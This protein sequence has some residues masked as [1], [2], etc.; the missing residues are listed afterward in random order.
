MFLQ[1]NNLTPQNVFTTIALWSCIQTHVTSNAGNTVQFCSQTVTSL[2]RMQSFLNKGDD[3]SP[4]HSRKGVIT[5]V[6]KRSYFSSKDE[7]ISVVADTEYERNIDQDR[8]KR[9]E[10]K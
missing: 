5:T 9:I 4:R 1:A 6:A 10:K 3:V 8:L 2:A 7:P